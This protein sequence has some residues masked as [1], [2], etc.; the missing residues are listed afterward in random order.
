MLFPTSEANLPMS[1][2]LKRLGRRPT[3]RL[4]ML[5]TRAFMPFKTIRS[6]LLAIIGSLG[7]LIITLGANQFVDHF[8]TH[9]EAQ[10]VTSVKLV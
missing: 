10:E 3:G 1:L 8:A 5:D 4:T 7:L 2:K 6:Y 9:R